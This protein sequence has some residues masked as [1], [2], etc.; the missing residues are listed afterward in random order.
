MRWIEVVFM[1]SPF[2]VCLEKSA[3]I[4][5]MRGVV[6]ACVSGEMDWV[7]SR[8][9]WD[10]RLPTVDPALLAEVLSYVLHRAAVSAVPLNL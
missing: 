5:E 8:A 1:V 10:A 9:Y 2:E 3:L 4:D 6:Q 7:R